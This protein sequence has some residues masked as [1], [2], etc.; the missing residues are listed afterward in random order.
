MQPVL[1]QFRGRD[2]D[3]DTLDLRFRVTYAVGLTTFGLL[4]DHRADEKGE[5]RDTDT[6]ILF[7][8]VRQW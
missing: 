2:E 8:V 7:T 6:R 5:S 3:H 4:L 1:Q